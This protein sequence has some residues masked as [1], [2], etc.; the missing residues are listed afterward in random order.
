[1]QGG[2]AAA[3][4]AAAAT[5]QHRELLERY[6]LVR[7]R[8]RGSFAQVWEARH[9]RTGLSVAVKIL[10][11]AGLL[12][13][14][15]PIRK[16][17]REI[18][19]MRLLNHPHIVRFHEAIA[20]GD[21]GGHVY[22]VMELATQGQLYDYVT[23]LGRLREDDA[24]RI[25][26]QIISGAEYC[27]HNMVVHRDLKLENI[28]MDSEMNVKIVDFGFS[29]FFRHN[30]VLSASCGS[31]EY[32]APELLAGRKYVGPPVDVWSCGV[33]LYILFCGRLPF[34]SADVS[35]LH[36]IIKRGEFSIPPYVPDDAR[37]LI[38]SMLIVRPDKRLTI[39]EVR[40]HR[41]LQHSIPRYLA[42][43]PLNAR[44]QITRASIDAETV[45]KV[46]GHGFERRYLV[47][48]LE[49]R[50]ENEATVAYN[51][52]LNKK[53]DAPT[54]YVWTIDVY[55]EAGQSNTTGAAEAT[56]S[57]AAGE[58]PVAV[59][60]EDDGRNNGW[61]LGGVEF[62]ECPREAMRAIAA[63]LRET[64]VVYAHDDDDRG[65]YGK[66]LCARFAGAAGVR[67]IIR[68]Y[69]AATDDAPS[70]SSSAA[71]AG[72][73]S[74]RGEAGHGGGV[75]VDDAVLESLSAAVFFE[76]QLYKSE[77]EG[78]YLMDLKRLSGPQLQYLNICSE[79]SSKLRA[80]N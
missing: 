12:A 79:L 47:E 36:R 68:S 55:Q 33:I 62:H 10:N 31:R 6:E 60:G 7:V 58:P 39:T 71:S 42:M 22:I 50:V 52:I 20:G 44:T 2:G 70:S 57:S 13:S 56:G 43:P 16:V 40:T 51:L 29:K 25:F 65:R 46:V 21:G 61:A 77:G 63:A 27:H 19:V 41:W 48:S 69:L 1:M 66:L 26:Q 3:S 14:G 4:A 38:S 17:E 18:A 75:P 37:D 9:R 59:A 72:G 28:L 8:G 5:Q 67:R 73:G 76:I 32:A 74:G 64:G 45:D 11:L 80:I 54:R 24:R 35:E 15:I 78:N 34:D 23:Q 53:F 49:N 30:K